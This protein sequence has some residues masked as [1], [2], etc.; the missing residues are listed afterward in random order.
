MR[1]PFIAGNWKMNLNGAEAEALAGALRKALG[2]ETPVDV[3]VPCDDRTV[4]VWIEYDNERDGQGAFATVDNYMPG[5]G[6]PEES[7]VDYTVTHW[8]EIPSPRPDGRNAGEAP[9][10]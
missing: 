7:A 9:E 6:W 10:C 8:R 2:A 1:R 3:A 5:K 4:L